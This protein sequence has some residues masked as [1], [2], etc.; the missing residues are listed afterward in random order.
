MP[1][2][3]VIYLMIA[4][5]GA[6]AI[7]FGPLPMEAPARTCAGIFFVA[8]VLW[9]TEAVPL[10][11]TSL[12]ILFCEL[13]FLGPQLGVKGS[14]YL[15]PFF[16]NVVALF[17]GGL[18][19]AEA[20]RKYHID[21]W[22]AKTV[23]AIAGTRPSM[24]LLAMM[25]VTAV[26][27]MWMSNTATT[28]MM[29]IIAGAV[30][31]S[32]GEDTTFGKALFLGIPFAANLGGMMTPVGTPPNAI[33]MQQINEH[34]PG[35]ITFLGWMLAAMPLV[36]VLLLV[37]WRVLLLLYPPPEKAVT[38]D[39][40]THFRPDRK[41]IAVMAL[42][43]L[44]VVLWLSKGVHGMASGTVALIPAIVFLGT[45]ILEKRDFKG[46]S[47]DVLFL[48]GGGLSLAV[49]MTTSG[50]DEVVVEAMA[51]EGLGTFG[52][53]V[54]FLAVG[55]VLT[56]FMSNTATANLIIPLAFVIPAVS[57]VPLAVGT[58]L[59]VSAVMI[60][61]VSTPP[62]AIAYSSGA[63]EMKDMA[64]VGIIIS[65]CSLIVVVTLGYQ[66]WRLLGLF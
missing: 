43:F 4:A 12:I 29:L 47:W 16:S 58:A 21:E 45:G 1:A 24:V 35:A 38:L 40:A 6:L 36:V 64:R 3:S 10:Y 65:A 17:L 30:V 49:A 32:L 50:L 54:T 39:T 52:V 23:L 59:A 15:S 46:I 63:V 37:L 60:L 22:V 31:V 28:A 44:T 20:G 25:L 62:N 66:W 2:R 57:A 8:L 13:A 18:L 48:V 9:V 53:L 51:L 11:V 34:A 5:V 7:A 56:T 27:S 33:A 42:F 55:A 26:L 61:P 19:L 41:T 14:V